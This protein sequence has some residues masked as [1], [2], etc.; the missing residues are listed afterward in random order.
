MKA[1]AT[2]LVALVLSAPYAAAQ[3]QR[4][5]A[6][7]DARALVLENWKSQDNTIK[8]LSLAHDC[9]VIDDI[10]AKVT[11]QNIQREMDDFERN[12]GVFDGNPDV[13]TYS[14]NAIQK[15]AQAAREGA[16]DQLTPADRA[17]IRRFAQRDSLPTITMPHRY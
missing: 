16:C 12:S 8:L 17:R 13:F 7:E 9:G 11:I 4:G 6:V 14:K 1:S 2:L 5:Q 10:S 15:G 3:R